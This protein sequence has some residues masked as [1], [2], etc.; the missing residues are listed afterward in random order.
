MLVMLD[1]ELARRVARVGPGTVWDTSVPPAS[2]LPMSLRGFA[3]VRCSAADVVSSAAWYAEFLGVPPYYE[4]PG[5]DGRPAYIEFRIGDRQAELG[6]VDSRFGPPA[7]PPGGAVLYWHVD[8]VQATFARLLAIGATESQ[9]ITSRGEGFVT[10]AVIDP[11][12]NVLGIMY[13][14]HYVAMLN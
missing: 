6:I 7:D 13:N 9:P 2:V 4:R 3:T 8:D 5:P 1:G 10:T 11:F 14:P 12:G